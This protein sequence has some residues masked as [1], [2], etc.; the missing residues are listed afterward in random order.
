[1]NNFTNALG[2]IAFSGL[3]YGIY[4]AS[5]SL[6]NTNNRIAKTDRII[7]KALTKKNKKKFRA[8]RQFEGACSNKRTC[9]KCYGITCKNHM[10]NHASLVYGAYFVPNRHTR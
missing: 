8:C 9:G 10:E 5:T 4:K 6:S 2:C 1:M 3:M 7:A